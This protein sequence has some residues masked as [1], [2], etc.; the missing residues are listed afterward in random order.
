M[1]RTAQRQQKWHDVDGIR[2]AIESAIELAKDGAPW[3]ESVIDIR[4]C[5]ARYWYER[6]MP[7]GAV[8]NTHSS[9]IWGHKE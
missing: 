6:E 2:D 5:P 4:A 3:S 8:P 7:D 1:T 9:G